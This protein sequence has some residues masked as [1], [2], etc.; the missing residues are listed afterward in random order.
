MLEP[1]SCDFGSTGITWAW[2]WDAAIS[3]RSPEGAYLVTTQ[4]PQGLFDE[5]NWSLAENG[6][7]SRLFTL[8]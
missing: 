5:R 1:N 6:K 4:W 7:C 2:K 8:K 3:R